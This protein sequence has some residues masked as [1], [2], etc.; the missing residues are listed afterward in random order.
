MVGLLERLR[1][2]DARFVPDTRTPDPEPHFSS[3]W[4]WYRGQRSLMSLT[5]SCLGLLIAGVVF[6]VAEWSTGHALE[7][8]IMT[9]LAGASTLVI[10]LVA[11]WVRYR[12]E[13]A[14][15]AAAPL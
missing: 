11:G 9:P 1:R 8:E 5:G 7:P 6:T 14:A 10:A 12:Y 4:R 2:L 15:R 3:Y 13:R